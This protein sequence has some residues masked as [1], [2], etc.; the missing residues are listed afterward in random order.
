M[1][2][3]PLLLGVSLAANAALVVLQT[4]DT[5]DASPATTD[6]AA[7]VAS[8]PLPKRSVAASGEAK[9][10]VAA[11]ESGNVE[12]LRDELSAAGL[13]DETVRDI[14]RARIQKRYEARFR[15][16]RSNDAD[17]EWWKNRNWW[18]DQSKEQ[19]AASKAL[20]AEMKSEM[21]RV[22]GE[23][24]MVAGMRDNPWMQRQYG[25][26]PPDKRQALME[27]EQDYNELSQELNQETR[28]FRM[29]SDAEKTR[30]LD[31]E[32]RRDLAEIL[33]PEELADYERRQ[34]RTAQQ[35]R[36]RMTQMDATEAE[37]TA[38]F[39][40]QKDFDERYAEYDQWGNRM[41]QNQTQEEREARSAAEKNMKAEIRQALGDDRYKAYTRSQ[42][43]DY[44]QLTNATKRFELPADT[45][46]KIYD[47]RDEVPLAATKIADDESLTP[48][49]KKEELKKLAEATRDRVRGML[50]A[51]V[52]QV[53][54]DNNNGMQWV[55][56]LEQGTIITFDADG[57]QKHRRIEQPPKK[58]ASDKK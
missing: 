28:N 54:F 57:S 58:P 43:H 34:S 35:L 3:L 14:V 17:Q 36:W 56:Q 48:D 26:I 7:S 8:A 31:A 15:A 45:P 23:D 25:Y 21:I 5:R 38:I 40:I 10:I 24:P 37:Y 16:L 42:D 19:R 32:K 52:A 33:S 49:Q 47:L 41:R 30:Y 6:G 4:R 22:L 55:R 11:I 51:E 44:Q 13:D 27:L 12:S 2:V 18:D 53:Y 29:P 46:A 20:Q 50:G 9:A 1:K 39:E